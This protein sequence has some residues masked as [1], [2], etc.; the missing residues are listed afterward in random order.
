MAKHGRL[1]KPAQ[2][3]ATGL[4]LVVLIGTTSDMFNMHHIVKA[5]T[6]DEALNNLGITTGK[7]R[8]E[9]R[10]IILSDNV[11]LF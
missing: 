4:F 9:V 5:E 7:E 6:Q 10:P 11:F 3:E 2:K 8:F 1:P